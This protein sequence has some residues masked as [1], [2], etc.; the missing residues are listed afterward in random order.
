MSSKS[1]QLRG[2]RIHSGTGSVDS[3][4]CRSYCAS[5]ESSWVARAVIVSAEFGSAITFPNSFQQ[6]D[7]RAKS[8]VFF[9]RSDYCEP[10]QL[11]CVPNK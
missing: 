1:W 5:R 3:A 8:L 9:K 6:F 4:G 11:E 10:D 2:G 7:A